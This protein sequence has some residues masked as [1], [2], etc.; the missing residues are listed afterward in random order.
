MYSHRHGDKARKTE[1][2][3]ESR[4]IEFM[5]SRAQLLLYKEEFIPGSKTMPQA[6][7]NFLRVVG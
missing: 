4:S 7:T 6:Q 5:P 2:E 1:T 3:I